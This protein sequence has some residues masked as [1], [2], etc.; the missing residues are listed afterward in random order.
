VEFCCLSQ[1]SLFFVVFVLLF[2]VW[3]LSRPRSPVWTSG[4]GPPHRVWNDSAGKKELTAH[5][6]LPEMGPFY[7]HVCTT[8]GVPPDQALLASFKEKNA[9]ALTKLQATIAGKHCHLDI[10]LA[11]QV[12]RD[13][14]TKDRACC[15]F[16]VRLALTAADATENL[17]ETEIRDAMLAKASYLSKTGAK[18]SGCFLGFVCK[19][20][21]RARSDLL[22]TRL[23]AQAEAETAFRETY[24]KSASVG[25]R[26][27]VTFYLIRLG[28]CTLR[29][30]LC[31]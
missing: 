12:A 16:V 22:L 5:I 13:F 28:A 29:C 7:E 3:P 9:A 8:L 14:E 11:S 2:D 26:M 17:G 25:Q 31:R 15:A 4:K 27:D 1:F 23:R 24:D 21:C 10:G 6:R 18:V 20:D 19:R 30:R